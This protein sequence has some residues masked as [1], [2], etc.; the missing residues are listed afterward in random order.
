MTTETKGHMPEEGTFEENVRIWVCPVCAFGFDA[1]H[2]SGPTDSN[3]YFCPVC[4]ET[5]LAA[6]RD[7][8]LAVNA[9]LLGIVKFVAESWCQMAHF[10]Y[11]IGDIRVGSQGCDHVQSRL[12][13]ARINGEHDPQPIYS[14]ATEGG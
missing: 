13:L 4:E 7:R 11:E 1:S 3:I 12:L 5:S 9:E 10:C 6:E 2:T 8:L 14:R